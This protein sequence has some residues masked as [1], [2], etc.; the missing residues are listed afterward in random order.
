MGVYE[1][2][3]WSLTMPPNHQS[4]LPAADGRLVPYGPATYIDERQGNESKLCC[5]LN[6]LSGVSLPPMAVLRAALL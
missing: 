3:A 6:V 4:I 2:I 1:K 5:P